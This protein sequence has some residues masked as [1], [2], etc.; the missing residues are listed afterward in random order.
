MRSISSMSINTLKTGIKTLPLSL[1]L[2]VDWC[3]SKTQQLLELEKIEFVDTATVS[4]NNTEPT[5]LQ[6]SEKF[7][8]SINYL[9]SNDNID[10]NDKK[11]EEACPVNDEWKVDPSRDSC[12]KYL[13]EKQDKDNKEWY[14]VFNEKSLVK[15]YISSNKCDDNWC[16]VPVPTFDWNWTKWKWGSFLWNK[17]SSNEPVNLPKTVVNTDWKPTEIV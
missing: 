5:I 11:L 3:V 10:N 14:W 16:K 9:A 13:E 15:K 2:L 7:S 1:L 12:Q 4:L 17:Y 6:K 8:L